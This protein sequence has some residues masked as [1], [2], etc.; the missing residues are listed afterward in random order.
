PRH[1][2]TFTE[3]AMLMIAT[4]VAVMIALAIV[5][6]LILAATKPDSFRI[7]RSATINAAPDKVFPLI[8]DFQ[9]WRGWSPWE[10]KD[11]NLKRT[12]SGAERGKGAVYAWEGNKN[13][14]S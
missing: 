10:N 9:Q 8:N 11:P 14:G 7:E 5:I 2:F 13:V 3:P 6:V 1:A 4:I 12:Y